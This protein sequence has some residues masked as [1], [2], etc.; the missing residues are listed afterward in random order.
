MLNVVFPIWI[1]FKSTLNYILQE[2]ENENI[3]TNTILKFKFTKN[4]KKRNKMLPLF[5]YESSIVKFINIF[6]IGMENIN[7]EH[8]HVG[9]I[10]EEENNSENIITE[11]AVACNI[12]FSCYMK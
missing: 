8:M 11:N 9:N 12:K 1:P 5:I 7:V 3:C 2:F 4:K 10:Y 6:N